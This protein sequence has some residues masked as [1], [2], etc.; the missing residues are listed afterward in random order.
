MTGR[1]EVLGE[2]GQWHEVGNVVSV[3]LD[4]EQTADPR[5]EAYRRHDALD[6]LVYSR[7]DLTAEITI[8][9]RL[10]GFREACTRADEAMRRLARQRPRV[11]DQDGDAVRPAW[12][13]PYGPARRRR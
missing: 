7:P 11:I 13:S 4:T 10:E 5:D 12:Q 3:E 8:P 6:A 1:L 2:D 9:V